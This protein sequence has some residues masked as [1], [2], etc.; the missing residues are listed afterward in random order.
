MKRKEI[1]ITNWQFY[2]FSRTIYDSTTGCSAY[3]RQS[4][5]IKV[6][7]ETQPPLQ[8]VINLIIYDFKWKK[9]CDGKKILRNMRMWRHSRNRKERLECDHNTTS[10]HSH[11][12]LLIKWVWTC[13]TF[14]LDSQ[15]WYV[16][17]CEHFVTISRVQFFL[18]LL[19]SIYIFMSNI[20][21]VYDNSLV[22]RAAAHLVEYFVFSLLYKCSSAWWCQVISELN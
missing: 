9:W 2:Q 16:W 20:I 8:T 12:I 10:C 1:I 5:R 7:E 22:K 3:V 19:H 21:I 18:L 11:T 14:F 4:G 17:E 15:W 13:K 6:E